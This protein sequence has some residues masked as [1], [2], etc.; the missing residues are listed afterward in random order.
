MESWLGSE[1]GTISPSLLSA[2]NDRQSISVFAGPIW[3]SLAFWKT[4]LMRLD[5]S[6]SIF[7]RVALQISCSTA[8]RIIGHTRSAGRDLSAR[9][10]KLDTRV[11]GCGGTNL[12]R[13]ELTENSGNA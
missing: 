6:W 1:Q 10:R 13:T 11:C 2:R 5:L 12:S 9:L 7:C 3:R 4:T 8:M